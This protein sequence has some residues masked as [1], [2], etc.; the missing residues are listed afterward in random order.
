MGDVMKP[1]AT[2]LTVMFRLASSCASALD[3]AVSP[4]FDA[5]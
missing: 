4:P 1:G 5:A 3:M 2:Q